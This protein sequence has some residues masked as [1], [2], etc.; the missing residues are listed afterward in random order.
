MLCGSARN[1]FA[2]LIAIIG[3]IEVSWRLCKL[4]YIFTNVIVS[5]NL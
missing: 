1:V 5:L 2:S 3:V 4:L